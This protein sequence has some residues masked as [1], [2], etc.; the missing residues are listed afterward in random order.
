M[1]NLISGDFNRSGQITKVASEKSY[2][3][4]DKMVKSGNSWTNLVANTNQSA[5][6]LWEKWGLIHV[7]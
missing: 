1:C 6:Q 4:G 7:T 5:T 2:Q 3:A